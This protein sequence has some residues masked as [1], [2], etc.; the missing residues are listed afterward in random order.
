MKRLLIGTIFYTTEED[1]SKRS[2]K[3]YIDEEDGIL[4][5]PRLKLIKAASALQRL[6]AQSGDPIMHLNV[7]YEP[8]FDEIAPF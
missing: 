6:Q 5:L 7:I 2:L 3:V 4:D 1:A 8:D